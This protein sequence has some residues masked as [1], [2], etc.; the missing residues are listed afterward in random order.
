MVGGATITEEIHPGFKYLTLSYVTSLFRP[1]IIADLELRK[2]GYELIPLENSF[3]PFLDGRYLAFG[4]GNE[5][6]GDRPRFSRRDAEA[7]PEY[8]A[9]LARLAAALRPM[10]AATPP[11]LAQLKPGQ[12]LDM[13][14]MARAMKGLSSFERSQLVKVMTMS[15]SAW[16]DE[17]FESEE[18]KTM[19]AAG[20]SIGIWGGPSHSPAPPS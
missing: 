7:W 4:P 15:T 13:L 19:L 10:L 12:M 5:A 18:V 9:T 20:G 8:G 17:W 2:Y 3:I 14:P 6:G 11:D 1:E 16:L